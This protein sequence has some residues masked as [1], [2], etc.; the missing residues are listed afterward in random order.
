MVC[1]VAEIKRKQMEAFQLALAEAERARREPEDCLSET[2][3]DDE[4]DPEDLKTMMAYLRRTFPNLNSVL[5]VRDASSSEHVNIEGTFAQL[6]D[7]CASPTRVAQPCEEDRPSLELTFA[8]LDDVPARV[9][10]PCEEERPSCPAL[11]CA[12][13]RPS[14]ELTSA[15]LDDVCESP[16]RVASFHDTELTAGGAV[17]DPR[18]KLRK[19][20][21]DGMQ[22]MPQQRGLCTTCQTPYANDAT[23]CYVCD[24]RKTRREQAEFYA[25]QRRLLQQ[26]PPSVAQLTTL[27]STFQPSC[28]ESQHL[29][30]ATNNSHSASSSSCNSMSMMVPPIV[31]TSNKINLWKFSG[32][33]STKSI[34]SDDGPARQ[35]FD[36]WILKASPQLPPHQ[37]GLQPCYPTDRG[38]P[39][40]LNWQEGQVSQPAE[41]M[42]QLMQPCYPSNPSGQPNQLGQPCCPSSPSGQP[43]QLNSQGGQPPEGRGRPLVQPDRGQPYQCQLN[44]Q[45]MGRPHVQPDR[46]QPYQLQLNSQEGRPCQFDRGTQPY[47]VNYQGGPSQENSQPWPPNLDNKPNRMVTLRPVVVSNTVHVSLP[48]PVPQQPLRQLVQRRESE[49]GWRPTLE[50][51]PQLMVTLRHVDPPIKLSSAVVDPPVQQ[52]GGQSNSVYNRPAV[53]LE[54]PFVPKNPSGYLSSVSLSHWRDINPTWPRKRSELALDHVDLPIGLYGP[55]QLFYLHVLGFNYNRWGRK[56][57]KNPM[58]KHN[59]TW[60]HK[61]LVK[62][63]AEQVDLG[64][65][66]KVNVD[67]WLK[68]RGLEDVTQFVQHNPEVGILEYAIQ[69]DHIQVPPRFTSATFHMT[70][71]EL[72]ANN[73]RRGHLCSS[74]ADETESGNENRLSLPLVYTAKVVADLLH[75]T[76]GYYYGT[77]M[78]GDNLYHTFCFQ[79]LVPANDDV[80]NKTNWERVH[81][82]SNVLLN[83]Q[84]WFEQCCSERI[85]NNQIV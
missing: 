32:T 21:K 52:V 65:K 48:S 6:A 67:R 82:E 77:D 40:Q 85:P 11:P 79:T 62:S 69:R 23:R 29:D 60:E 30:I 45:E 50:Q 54:P 63:W 83:R 27:Q 76:T 47:Q 68:S 19:L 34:C 64:A 7:D 37:H 41:G 15:Q 38:Q 75:E 12:E 3:G 13:N 66:V 39:N 31:A 72:L 20:E 49:Q 71:P 8:G 55:L 78:L 70:F 24:Q 80:K 81:K 35:Q 2:D 46:G 42:D 84:G 9:A 59:W 57:D 56:N 17:C 51:E 10:L 73:I 36:R 33:A 22:T 26:S 58:A 1:D 43:N 14:L 18:H 74:K 5:I 44:S 61:L 4:D 25:Q 53:C 16:A 28:V